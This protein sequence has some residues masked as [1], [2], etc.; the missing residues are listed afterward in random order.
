MLSRKARSSTGIERER[1]FLIKTLPAD[2][3]RYPHTLIEQG[4]LATTGRHNRSAEVRI[5]R[6]D[7]R[8]VLTVKKGHGTARSESEI[9]LDRASRRVLWTLTRG[10]RVTKVRYQIPYRG[11]TIELDVYRGAVQGLAVAEVEFRSDRAL[12]RFVP[13]DWFGREI[14]GRK[15]FS[16][17]RLAV[18]GWKGRRRQ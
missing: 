10:L 9:A 7:G 18:T 6:M 13:P 14:T 11:H 8:A 15:E 16:N 12:R 17:S 3:S 5:R 1:K 4:Y 2:R